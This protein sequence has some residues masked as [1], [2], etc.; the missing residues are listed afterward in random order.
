[1]DNFYLVVITIAVLLLIVIL[2][3]LGIIMNSQKNVSMEFPT[4][5]PQSCPDYWKSTENDDKNTVCVVPTG[6]VNMGNLSSDSSETGKTN[7]EVTVGYD[8][9]NNTINFNDDT[10]WSNCN[11]NKW[12]LKHQIFWNGVAEYS[13]C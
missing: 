3:Y 8:E 6:G 11:K 12:A 13:K 5:E 9:N 4:T 10:E 1:M 2:T 7:L